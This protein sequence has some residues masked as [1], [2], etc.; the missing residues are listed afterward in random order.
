M[1]AKIRTGV[2]LAVALCAVGVFAAPAFAKEKI[3]FGEFEASITGQN[4]ETTPGELRVSKAEG[5]TTI[6]GL[7]LGPYTFGPKNKLTGEQEVE[8][9][10]GAVKVTGE[11]KKEK[12]S[13]LTLKLT[14]KKCVAWAEAGV[15]Q[16]EVPTNL[17]LG[18][19]LKSNFSAEVGKSESSF[20]I[21]PGVV[22]F[23]GALKKC[24]VIIP[25]QTIP[26]KENEAK[27]YEEIVEYENE[28]FEPE[29][30]EHSKHKKEL[31]PSG[32]KETL[33]VFFLE[34]FHH[35]HT[36]MSQTPPCT[37]AKGA[38]N[39]KIVTE[40]GPYLGMLEFTNGHLFGE[41][42]DL[43]VKNGNLKFKE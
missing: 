35:I 23:K 13:E 34:K 1:R 21:E 30:I 31:Y 2:A 15:A 22:S 32:E 20:E 18:I 5:S 37:N 28:S 29:G 36:Y 39:G 7:E 12:S 3:I 27:E 26:A 10:C 33:N 4:L 19:K 25:R 6:N 11:V 40:E 24:P 17:S 9:P 42:E 41:I 14:F 43:E 38:E 16:Q 8:S